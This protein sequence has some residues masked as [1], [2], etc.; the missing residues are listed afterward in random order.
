[1]FLERF[2]EVENFTITKLP[3]GG[4]KKAQYRSVAAINIFLKHLA[5]AILVS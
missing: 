3:L 5:M 2:K 1:M 4:S